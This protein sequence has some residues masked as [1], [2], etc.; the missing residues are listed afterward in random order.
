M[1]NNIN[2]V[3]VVGLC[4]LTQ[5][6]APLRNVFWDLITQLYTHP[7]GQE[8][9]ETNCTKLFKCLRFEGG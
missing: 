7:R 5:G 1:T 2:P 3:M 9:Q 8:I 6:L 4:C